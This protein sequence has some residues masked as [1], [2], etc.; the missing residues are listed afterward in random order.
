VQGPS[1][2]SYRIKETKEGFEPKTS[3]W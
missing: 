2:K 3:E 1:K